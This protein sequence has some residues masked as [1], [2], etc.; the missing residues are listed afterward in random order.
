MVEY[1]FEGFA[2]VRVPCDQINQADT[3]SCRIKLSFGRSARRQFPQHLG[4]HIVHA[5][6]LHCEYAA[7]HIEVFETFF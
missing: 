4:K 5:E 2:R 3:E 6:R 7:R 1:R